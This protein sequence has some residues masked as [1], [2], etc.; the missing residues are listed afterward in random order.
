V[1]LIADDLLETRIAHVAAPAED[2][3]IVVGCPAEQRVRLGARSED[4]SEPSAPDGAAGD[5]VDEGC[6]RRQGPAAA[7]E[8]QLYRRV[9]LDQATA[10]AP[11]RGVG[12]GH[13][14]AALGLMS[15]ALGAAE[16][17]EA[18]RSGVRLVLVAR[19]G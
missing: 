6:N 14:V 2:L 19:S 13:G 9:V 4:R 8:Q 17:L 5:H 18:E 11:R 12:L 15:I 1:V 16:R 7:R 3:Q 10:L